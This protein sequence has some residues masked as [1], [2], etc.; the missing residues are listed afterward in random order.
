MLIDEKVNTVSSTDFK[1]LRDYIKE[2][3]G[4]LIGDGK[5]Y[6]IESR[7]AKLLIE[8]GSQDFTEFYNTLTSNSVPGLRDKVIDAITTHETSW[9]RD[10]Y[11]FEILSNVIL[12]EWAEN[13]T[14]KTYRIWSCGCS[15][16]QEAYS[17]CMIVDKFA[18][19]NDN[20]INLDQ[21]E[22][23]ATDIAPRF[24]LWLTPADMT[25]FP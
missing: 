7:F 24:F 14:N 23:V 5:E 20:A 9:F 4:I 25:R 13:K 6:L 18:E 16:G 19:E 17:V 21:I 8:T 2:S 12:P 15:T 11:P 1:K 3:C 22:L 10:K